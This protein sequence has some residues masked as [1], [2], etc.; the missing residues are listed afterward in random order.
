MRGSSRTR[1]PVAVAVVAVVAVLG[2]SA[3][4]RFGGAR[5]AAPD[6]TGYSDLSWDGQALQ[7][8]GFTTD[9]ITLAAAT[10]AS[11]APSAS[12]RR[13]GRQGG[14]AAAAT[15]QADQVRFR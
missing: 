11:P 15:A 2:L 12:P 7:S 14:Q 13:Q 4:G 5:A 9:E 10:E 8:I 1:I 3:C 6:E